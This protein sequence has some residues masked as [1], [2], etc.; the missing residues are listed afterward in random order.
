MAFK[1]TIRK[2]IELTGVG[3]HSGKKVT[4]VLKPSESGRLVFRRADLGNAETSIQIDRVEAR[5]S[6]AV[7][8]D[9]FE[10]RTVEHLLAALL[11][12]AVDSLVIELDGDEVPILDGS[13]LPFIR[14]LEEAGTVFLEREAPV[15]RIFR[16]FVVSD[17]DAFIKVEAGQPDEGLFLSYTI[18]YPHPLIG[19]QSLGL[20][21]D[22]ETFIRQV[23]PARTF[24]FL[25]DAQKLRAAGLALGASFENTVVLDREKVLSGP[26]RFDDEFVRHKLL[27]MAGDLAL[28]GRPL[29]GAFSA[30]KAGHKLHLM[31]VRFIHAHPEYWTET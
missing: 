29:R 2:D 14:A 8:G 15:L 13:A 30:H 22:E 11:A 26:L 4:L 16:P 18:E 6:T 19:R 3:V 9:R 12:M 24:G 1:K 5:N 20:S 10:I 21:L 27:D 23:A 31:T 7:R 17:G 25:E 28:L